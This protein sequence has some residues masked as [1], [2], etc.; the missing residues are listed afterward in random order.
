MLSVRA[1]LFLVTGVLF[2]VWLRRGYRNLIAMRTPGL[3]HKP[4]WAVG[5][6]FVP[7]MNFGRPI[8]IVNDTWRASDPE[9]PAGDA[10]WYLLRPPWWHAWWWACFVGYA[11][12]GWVAGRFSGATPAGFRT[13][14][15]LILLSEVLSLPAALLCMRVV[16]DVTRRQRQ[17]AVR[18]ARH[19]FLPREF[20]VAEAT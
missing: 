8:E 7:I 11:L 1:A 15:A 14:F 17:R 10:S 5:A 18:F 9:L 2:L 6:W 13:I 12:S 3:R 19:E 4:G 16:S 20:A